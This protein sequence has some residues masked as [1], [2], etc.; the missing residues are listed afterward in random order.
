M[1]FDVT[2]PASREAT[3]M[4]VFRH[5]E[6]IMDTIEPNE[7]GMRG[8]VE[9]Q[10]AAMENGKITIEVPDAKTKRVAWELTFFF[11]TSLSEVKVEQ[12]AHEVAANVQENLI[13]GER[14]GFGGKL[15]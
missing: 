5:I 8:P 12:F 15:P 11:E 13:E 3:A 10:L 6:K 7:D 9:I 4:D 14:F 1:K 2:D